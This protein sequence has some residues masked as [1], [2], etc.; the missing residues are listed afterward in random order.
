L[1]L[2]TGLYPGLLPRIGGEN[3]NVTGSGPAGE[4]GAKDAMDFFRSGVEDY[5]AEH[6][7]AELRSFMSVR[8][9]AYLRQLDRFA[10]GRRGLRVVEAG[11]GPGRMA[12]AMVERGHEVAAFD[13]S[14]EMLRIARGL[15]D[16]SSL[17]RSGFVV[18]DIERAPYRSS[19]FDVY[20]SAGVIEYLESDDSTLSEAFD[21]LQPGGLAITSV[22]N[23][24]SHAGLFD[25][26][27]EAGK[28]RPALLGVVNRALRFLG[29]RPV[30]PR[31]FSVRKHRPE[32]FRR[33][34]E[35]AGFEIM[36]DAFFYFLPWPHP[37]DRLFPRT[38]SGLGKFLEGLSRTPLKL[39]GE[40]YLV[41]ARKPLS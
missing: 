12:T 35:Q 41:V 31:H 40:G 30:R 8:Q 36:D 25:T 15:V 38:T 37:L 20:V 5:A 11:C 18:G 33:N 39:M 2:G 13:T 3:L 22:T 9:E 34:L 23:V 17:G 14:P 26:L 21:L 27:V 6:Y 7:D 19:H 4:G 16:S 1:P 28:R 29:R 32:S 10:A 24:F